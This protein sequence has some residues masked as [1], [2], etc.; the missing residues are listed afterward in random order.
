MTKLTN[1]Q[2]KR[3]NA[4]LSA[5]ASARGVLMG[6]LWVRTRGGNLEKSPR[7]AAIRCDLVAWLRDTVWFEKSGEMVIGRH[8]RIDTDVPISY[9]LIALMIGFKD[10]TSALRAHNDWRR[11][12][13]RDVNLTGNVVPNGSHVLPDATECG[14][15]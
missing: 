13:R 15:V 7:I 14:R 2:T 3:L 4:H 12:N 8:D 11:Q 9:P 1:E 5:G 10:H 6:E